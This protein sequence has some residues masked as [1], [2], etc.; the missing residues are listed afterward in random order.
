MECHLR[1]A[2]R[3][4]NFAVVEQNSEDASSFI[5]GSQYTFQ[6]GGR[7]IFTSQW[8]SLDVQNL[9]G[10][11]LI[12]VVGPVHIL[13]NPPAKHHEECEGHNNKRVSRS[14]LTV[15]AIEAE[16]KYK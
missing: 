1:A 9:I 16:V 10:S 14:E 8:R 11:D 7:T 6:L 3:D 12:N 15:G 13:I 5:L 2:D 4:M